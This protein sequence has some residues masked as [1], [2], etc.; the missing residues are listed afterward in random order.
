MNNNIK[1]IF[2]KENLILPNY[3]MLN[4]IDLMQT[5]YNRFGANYKINKNIIE[6]DKIIPNNKHTLF[7]LVDGMGSN[8]IEQLEDASLLKT[9]KKNNLLTVS[10]STTGCVLTS[11]ATATYPNKHGIIG[12][13]SHLKKFN[14][15][16]YPLLFCERKT[17]KPLI[18][19][20][21][22]PKD[23]FKEESMFNKL[24][25]QT[26]VLYP[27]YICDSIYSK[28]VA[29]DE[30]RI[31]YNNY[32]ELPQKI[33]EI[34]NM[35]KKTFTYLY[36]PEIDNLE[37]ENGV[38]SKIV[39][40]ELKKIEEMLKKLIK[41]KDMTIIITAD[42]GQININKDVIMDFN[43][44]NDYFYGM[45]GIDFA[46]ATFYVKKEKEQDFE[47]E[48]NKD[49]KDEMYL[50]KTAEFFRNQIFG[51]GEI[52]DNMKNNIGEYIGICKNNYCF[53]NSDNLDEYVGKTLGNH[54]GFS[55]DEMLIPLII[56]NT[57]D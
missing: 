14:I 35:A 29:T 44:Y 50:F 18:F 36:L 10:P 26:K 9:N 22:K 8:L 32:Q 15:D 23:V 20:G 7:I 51:L 1:E 39:K 33:K 5:I 46:T 4:I 27:K 38:N 37:H 56:I 55:K 30:K 34:N 16:Y 47:R 53:I 40:A 49:F 19:Y 57:N 52:S 24:N 11:I 45:P 54:S 48:F 6:L 42:H 21:I 31:S 17:E 25:V 13:Y 28:F 41:I 2:A 12:W 3:N 43:K